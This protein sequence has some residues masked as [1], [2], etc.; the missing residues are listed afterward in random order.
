MTTSI[1]KPTDRQLELLAHLCS[2]LNI[3]EA[4][5]KI[6]VAERT[7]YNMMGETRRRVEANS[8]EQLVVIA[9]QKKWLE[10]GEDG[11]VSVVTGFKL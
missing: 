1:N 2:G 5:G 9:L 8:T 7:A 11:K 4:A 6:F 3:A 10:L